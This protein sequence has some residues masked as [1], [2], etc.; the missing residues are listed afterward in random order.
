MKI[1]RQPS[2]EQGTFGEWLDNN[3]DHLCYTVELP[4]NDNE[5]DKSCIPLDTY[6][7]NQ[8]ESPKHGQVWIVQNVAGRSNIEIHT[9]N[10]WFQLLG[11]IGVGDSIGQL[12]YDSTEYPEYTGKIFPA[13]LNSQKT[14]DMLRSTLPATF[15]L[16]FE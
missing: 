4:W 10:F 14:L 11:C 5:P 2:T 7:F 8:Y 3:G 15:N 13:V 12:E 6:T 1:I 16:T 9:A